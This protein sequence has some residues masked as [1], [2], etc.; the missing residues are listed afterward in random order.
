MSDF[1]GIAKA[2][3]GGD[4]DAVAELVE[5]ALK[6]GASAEQIVSDALIKGMNVVG[7]LF[8]KDELYVPEVLISAKAMKRGMGLLEP[9]LAG[10]KRQA[11][12]LVVLGTV[13]GDIHDIGKS[14]VK[15]MLE[16]V[17]F[18][19][20]DL[21]I[22]IDEET[23]VQKAAEVKPD[24]IGMSALLTTTMVNMKPTIDALREAGLRDQVKVMVGG[25]SVTAAFAR[26]IGADGT[27]R[28]A[29]A[30]V[31]LAKSLMGL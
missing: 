10:G 2:V 28:D 14:L 19:V 31:D 8:K 11:L 20:V 25:T 23:F 18:E 17:G 24:I 26:E 30:A 6:G 22:D 1:E 12:G 27:A 21:G 16:G 29:V 5:Q 15:T 7:D 13:K 3:L 9:L 4:E